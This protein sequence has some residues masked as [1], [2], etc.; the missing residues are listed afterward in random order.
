MDISLLVRFIAPFLPALTGAGQSA[1][2]AVVGKFGRE[3]WGH[4]QTLWRRLGPTIDERPAAA[5]AV[6]DLV[7]SPDDEDSLAQLRN[8]LKKLLEADPELA[9]ALAADMA[10]V[11][12]PTVNAVAK[13]SRNVAVGG[14]VSNSL[15]NTG[16][17]VRMER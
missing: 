15:I 14:S 4:A 10:Q 7:S 13:G 11:P 17:D 9:A 8:Q 3:A 16:D 6:A 2:E 1:I 12:A 5:E